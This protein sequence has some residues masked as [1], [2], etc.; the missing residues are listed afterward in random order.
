MYPY[1]YY[2]FTFIHPINQ[3]FSLIKSASQ[4]IFCLFS[5]I[6]R[7]FKTNSAFCQQESTRFTSKFAQWIFQLAKMLKFSS[8]FSDFYYNFCSFSQKNN[9]YPWV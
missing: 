6:A 1:T 9:D 8:S 4:A 2:H 7:L 5:I 3:L